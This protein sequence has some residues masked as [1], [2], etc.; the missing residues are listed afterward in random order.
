MIRVGILGVGGISGSH[1]AAWKEVEDAEVAALCDIRSEMMEK[2][3]DIPH[4]NDFETMIAEAKLDVVDICLPTYLHAEYSVRAMEAGLHVI[5]EKPVSLKKEDVSIIYEAAHRNGVRF[6]VAHVVRFWPE[7]LF[8]KDTYESGRYG[9]LLFGEMHR[10]ATCPGWSWDGWMRD[11]KRSGYVPFDLH[12]HDL[13]FLVF[14]FGAPDKCDPVRVR[15]EGQDYVNVRYGFKDFT[16]QCESAWYA[17][18]YPFTFGYRF[19]FET[20]IVEFKDGKV[21]VFEVGKMPVT[22]SGTAD[23][24]GAIPKSNAYAEEIKYFADC[25]KKGVDCDMVKPP[26]LESVLE[27]LNSL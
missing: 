18:T 14:A 26:E 25:V 19:V 24:G 20:G 27:A 3:P 13:D 2:Y 1:I 11:E 12:I 17:A 23:G 21:T 8:L 4:Y 10:L 6:M 15:S 16:V 22:V 9:K 7:Y 5:C